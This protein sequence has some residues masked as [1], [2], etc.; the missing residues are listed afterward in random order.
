MSVVFSKVEKHF[1]ISLFPFKDS[2]NFSKEDE[3]EQELRKEM[4]EEGSKPQVS[5]RAMS[6]PRS[7]RICDGKCLNNVEKK[8]IYFVFKSS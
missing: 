2:L 8:Q 3:L 1:I 5:W 4:E 6:M 7:E